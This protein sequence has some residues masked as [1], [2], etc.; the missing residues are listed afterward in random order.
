M[1]ERSVSQEKLANALG[2]KRQTV[3]L[4][5]TGQSSPN[6]EQLYKIASFFGISADWLLGLS[7]TKSQDSNI[8]HI[9]RYTGLT[10]A[11]VEALHQLSTYDDGIN[12]VL[13]F[14]NTFLSS[15]NLRHFKK[16]A[17][18]EAALRIS[19]NKSGL[20]A[21]LSDLNDDIADHLRLIE[22]DKS[23]RDEQI[24]S[25]LTSTEQTK[26]VIEVSTQE[27]SILY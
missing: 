8:Q 13:A 3:S 22:L 1:K 12:A 7:E 10:Q 4:Y 14:I 15:N 26:G 17:F 19:Y 5:K 6:T 20:G 23:K 11:A 16:A 18:Y 9:C 27:A 24:I 25:D 21:P 2:V